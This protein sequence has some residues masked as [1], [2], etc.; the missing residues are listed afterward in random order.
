M[1]S[2][3]AAESLERTLILVGAPGLLA[4]AAF[5]FASTLGGRLSDEVA[6]LAAEISEAQRRQK[7]QATASSSSLFALALAFLPAATLLARKLGLDGRGAIGPPRE[8]MRRN[9]GRAGYP[10]GLSDDELYGLGLLIGPAIAAPLAIGLALVIEEPLML[11]LLVLGLPL[12]PMLVNSQL[13][14]RGLVREKQIGRTFA[15]VVDLLVLTMKS[16]ASLTLALERVTLD[17]KGHPIG[18][19]VRALLSDMELGASN[20]EAFE[21]MGKRVPIPVVKQFADEVVQSEE[22]GQPIADALERMAD[23]VRTRRIQDARATA[24]K[25]KVMVLIPSMLVF[26]AALL[27]LFAPFIVRFLTGTFGQ[28]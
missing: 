16:G 7:R 1:C 9:Y 18:D 19:E 5:L 26:I 24:G 21:A 11:L 27:L 6:P 2:L 15:Y 23:R 3:L 17:Y 25:A 22:L 28:Q 14:S 13:Q 12:G 4:I 8:D 20:R 10:G